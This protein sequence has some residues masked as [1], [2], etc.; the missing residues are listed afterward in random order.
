MM[1]C[2]IVAAAAFGKPEAYDGGAEDENGAQPMQRAEGLA[3]PRTGH[4]TGSRSRQVGSLV[5]LK[6]A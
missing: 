4:R 6:R 5:I 3:A 1:L 2:F